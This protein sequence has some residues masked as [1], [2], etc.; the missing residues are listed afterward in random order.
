M[1]A[2]PQWTMFGAPPKPATPCHH[3]SASSAIQ[4]G[5][6]TALTSVARR[7]KQPCA[8]LARNADH[9]VVGLPSPRQKV[10]RQAKYSNN[11]DSY[12]RPWRI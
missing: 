10:R 9:D 8:C 12:N 11:S 2:G 4:G 5:V 6:P 7:P 3:T 1:Q